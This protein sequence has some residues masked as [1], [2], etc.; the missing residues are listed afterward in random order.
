[1][2]IIFA[3]WTV[4]P[5][6]KTRMAGLAQAERQQAATLRQWDEIRIFPKAAIHETDIFLKALVHGEQLRGHMKRVLNVLFLL[7]FFGRA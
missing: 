1:M 7:H 3:Q 5:G 2:F 4:D 6:K